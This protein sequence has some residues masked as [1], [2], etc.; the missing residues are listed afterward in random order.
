MGEQGRKGFVAHAVHGARFARVVKSKTKTPERSLV[1]HIAGVSS[2]SS[3]T[4]VASGLTV[5]VNG[6]QGHVIRARG[7]RWGVLS[8]VVMAALPRR[9][10]RGLSRAG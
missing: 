1:R 9:P 3:R 6:G 5:P 4:S 10:G 8:G 7:G 2:L